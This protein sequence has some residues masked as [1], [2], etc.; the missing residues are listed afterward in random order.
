MRV[1]GGEGSRPSSESL[2]V[3]LG[4]SFLTCRWRGEHSPRGLGWHRARDPWD[5]AAVLRV[6]TKGRAWPA[7]HQQVSPRFAHDRA[8]QRCALS[9]RPLGWCFA[10]QEL[11]W[12]ST[13]WT[14]HFLCSDTQCLLHSGLLDPTHGTMS[15]L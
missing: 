6:V 5:A 8:P 7:P 9:C 1:D 12:T 13:N 11:F 14:K 10:P 4:M 2:A 3:T 15:A